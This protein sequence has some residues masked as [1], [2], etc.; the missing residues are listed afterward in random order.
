[1][2][3]QFYFNVNNYYN[4]I[5]INFYKVIDFL[6]NYSLFI[7]KIYKELCILLFFVISHFM[8]YISSKYIRIYITTDMLNYIT[9]IAYLQKYE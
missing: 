5:N 2:Y 1:M 6:Q 7:C 9:D 4:S 8:I 3:K